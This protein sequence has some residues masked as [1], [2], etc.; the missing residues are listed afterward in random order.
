M[1]HI[2]EGDVLVIVLSCIGC[3]LIGSIPTGILVV[4]LLKGIDIRQHGSG[5][6]GATNVTRVLGM[7][8]GI[9]VLLVDTAKGFLPVFF[10][11]PWLIHSGYVPLPDVLTKLIL[12]V[13]AI[14]GHIW[15]IFGNFKGGK[16]VGTAGGVVLAVAPVATIICLCI[17]GITVGITRYVSVASMVAALCFP[18][19]VF[20]LG[21]QD[22]SLRVFSIILALLI[23]FTHRQN[24][25]RL[26]RG[27][28]HRIG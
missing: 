1:E 21:M 27:E 4:K 20:G 22:I 25:Y 17:W 7:K 18:I 5:S 19:A 10:L 14:A 24:I 8:Y 3:Y 16:G 6:S 13:F 28:E 11:A 26:S 2:V 23:V 12:G 9:L 15:T